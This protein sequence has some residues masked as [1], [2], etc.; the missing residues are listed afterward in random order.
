MPPSQ[1]LPEPATEFPLVAEFPAETFPP[2]R[3]R[4]TVEVPD[5]LTDRRDVEVKLH[6][7]TLSASD[8]EKV[9][10][11]VYNDAAVKKLL[12]DSFTV[13]GIRKSPTKVGTETVAL[14]YSYDNQW[15]V[16]AEL[17]GKKV[18]AQPMRYQPCITEKEFS[19]AVEIARSGLSFNLDGLEGGVIAI[20]RAEP[21][22]PYAGRR[23]ADVR[24][25]VPDERLARYFAI[26]DLATD[27]VLDAGSVA[28]HHG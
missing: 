3:D 18:I 27:N 8:G 19:R 26:V 7:P 16:E 21:D 1:L 5:G 17:V 2:L 9:L 4:P 20:E 15:A 14:F 10:A 24:F 13:I 22:D 12:G 11:A 23:L 6:K 25:F 28:D